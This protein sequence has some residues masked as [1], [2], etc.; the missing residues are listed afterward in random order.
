M[1]PSTYITTGLCKIVVG[2][3]VG[4]RVGW[5]VVREGRML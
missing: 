1:R 3:R 4:C 5:Q 2:T